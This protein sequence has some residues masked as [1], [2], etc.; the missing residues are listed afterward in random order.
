MLEHLDFIFCDFRSY[1]YYNYLKFWVYIGINLSSLGIS[2][3]V[4]KL[5]VI[6]IPI[7]QLKQIFQEQA[8]H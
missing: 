6:I 8:S 7:L 5:D 4:S 1:I 3:Q 2:Q